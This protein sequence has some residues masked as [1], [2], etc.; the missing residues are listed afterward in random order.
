MLLIQSDE[1]ESSLQWIYREFTSF[2]YFT[3]LWQTNF[4]IE[5]DEFSH[6]S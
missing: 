2:V 6:Q 3:K 5:A 1:F 4:V